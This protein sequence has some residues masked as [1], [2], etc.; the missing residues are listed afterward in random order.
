[1]KKSKIAA[2]VAGVVA[3]GAVCCIASSHISKDMLEA[4]VEALATGEM[5]IYLNCSTTSPVIY[6]SAFCLYCGTLWSVPGISG[7]YINGSSRCL[8]GTIL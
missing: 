6:C 8:C 7:Q 1:M 5:S 3:L 4:N 2:I